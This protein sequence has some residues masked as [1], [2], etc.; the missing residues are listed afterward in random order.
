MKSYKYEA[1]NLKG[2]ILKGSLTAEDKKEVIKFLRSK[3]YFIVKCRL[4]LLSVVLNFSKKVN[5][6]EIALFCKQLYEI[7]K[8]GID[9]NTGLEILSHQR[10]SGSMNFIINKVK[11]D[12][13]KGK[14]FSQSLQE[15][16]KIFPEFMI[17]M[18]R[19]GEQSG[20]LDNVL[21]NLYKYYMKEHKI[22]SKIRSLLAYPIMIL[23]T[24]IVISI[25]VLINIVPMIFEN[26]TENNIPINVE[27]KKLMGIRSFILSKWN[28]LF[29]GVIIAC[30]MLIKYKAY[31]CQ[32]VCDLKQK[33]P[34][35][36]KFRNKIFQI[37]F[38]KNLSM[39]ISSGIPVMQSLETI[40]KDIKNRFYKEKITSL[41]LQIGKGS[42]LTSSLE[43]TNLFDELF[44]AMVRIGEETGSLETMLDNIC[45]IY[46]D[47]MNGVIKKISNYIEPITIMILGVL[48]M[49][50][51]MKLI[52]PI[53][54]V[55]ESV[56]TIV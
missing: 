34:I 47:D 7:L 16:S 53:I 23:C 22:R 29:I 44:I 45:E 18:I 40:E 11:E 19:I 27:L 50:I 51:I 25:F 56:E 36:S 4:S 39:L 52:F 49:L 38:G 14:S 17:S 30:I 20:N 9:L 46:E 21:L 35:I 8:C 43:K 5:Y 1:V 48:V 12:I 10:F 3:E 37:R 13:Q 28:V 24:T 2:N 32:W 33:I 41:I 31:K 26:I 6:K 55:M 42:E 15:N 54:N